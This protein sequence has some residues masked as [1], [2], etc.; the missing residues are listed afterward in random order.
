MQAPNLILV[1]SDIKL[2]WNAVNVS[3][4]LVMV[5]MLI[6]PAQQL[7]ALGSGCAEKHKEACR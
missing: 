7:P 5:S 4:R 6:R 2:L 3:R 1:S